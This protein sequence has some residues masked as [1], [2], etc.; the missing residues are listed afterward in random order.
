MTPTLHPDS[1]PP[2]WRWLRPLLAWLPDVG[3]F[4]GALVCA[5]LAAL[6]VGSIGGCGGGV[7][8]EGTGTFTSVGSGP[9]TGLGS[10][11]VSGVRYDDSSATVSDDDGNGSDRSK[12][13]L[14]LVVDVEG[15]AVATASDGV[16]LTATATRV[17]TR[18]ALLGPA[19]GID[20]ASGSLRVLG[21]LVLVT[22]DT[23]FDSSLAGGLAAVA[24]GQLLEVWGLY[25]ASRTGWVATRVAP[26][27]AGS[28]YSVSGPVASVDGSQSF[29]VGS[30]RFAGSTAGL[31][32]GTIVQLKLQSAKD[33]SDRWQVS[34]QRADDRL[35]SQSD[36]AGLEGLVSAVA[37][38]TRFTVN[39]TLVDSSAARVDGTVAVGARV[40]VRGSLQAGVLVATRVQA[41]APETVRGFELKG[42]PSALDTA[43]RRF[44]LRGVTV[45]YAGAVF[46][47]GS[48]AALVGYTGT[49]EVKGR[50]SAD[51]QVLE[52]T[53][54]RFKD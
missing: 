22:G 16:T 38:A 52:A 53:S 20:L 23:A 44:L 43:A 14:G 7:G 27:A 2:R 9:I 48:A 13:A 3:A 37:S 49:L 51:R 17:R 19:A 6:L 30:Q 50:L 54:I 18:R 40:Q 31:A 46:D 11:V 42:T 39:G 12:L 34:T 35:P 10:I 29:T 24:D 4:C 36:G 45:A 15:G 26:A 47:G 28:T 32:A 1:R 5:V 8:T 41:S 33:A 21:Q 25:D